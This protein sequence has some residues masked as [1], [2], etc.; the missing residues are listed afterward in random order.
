MRVQVVGVQ[1]L[2]FTSNDGNAI[3]GVNLFVT[4]TEDRV[5]GLVAKK[6][7]VNEKVSLPEGLGVGKFLDVFFN[8]RKKIDFIA[9]AK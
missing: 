2:D 4:H 5:E 7:F 3:K 6:F 1:N 8:D 9:L